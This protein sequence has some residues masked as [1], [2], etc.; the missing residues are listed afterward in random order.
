MKFVRLVNLLELLSKKSHLLLGPRGTGKSYLIREQL[1]EQALVINLLEQ[2]LFLRLTAAPWE[3]RSMVRAA[4]TGM[5]IVI[6]EIQKI[7]A[8]MDE[9][10]SL[11]ESEGRI[12]LLTG[13]SARR[14]RRG[15]ANLLAGRAW[16]AE[17]LPLTSQE[18]PNLDL[19]RYLRFGGLPFVYASPNPEEELHAYVK[20]YLQEEI[21]AEG[22]TRNLPAFTRFLTTAAM[23][24]GTVVNYT[25]VGA[26]AEV[27]PSTVRQY[28]QVLEDTLLGFRVAP[29]RD[30][31]K[32][33]AV[34]TE[35]FYLFDIGVTHAIAGTKFIERNSDLYG[36]SFEHFIA[37]EL[38]AYISY[39]R[40][41]EPLLFWRSTHGSEV[42]FIVDN[43][44]AIEVKAT[45]R[46][47]RSDLKGLLAFQ[48][49]GL[50]NKCILVSQ[51]PVERLD[52][53]IHIIPWEIFLH[54][55]WRE[56]L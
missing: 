43:R 50:G 7:P 25:K 26:D 32:R 24:S 47:Q 22:I 39:R 17:M 29:K 21:Q 31:K 6:D 40:T 34:A 11:I 42:D 37:Q 14:L 56:Q 44:F 30:T 3:I 12:F 1:A 4:P 35:K 53:N 28:L 51:D 19:Q 27:S 55:L 38:R 52:Q 15:G 23:L 20:T 5:T 54:R 13:S 49:E 18:I 45:Q 10:H 36:R 8:L 33:K 48:E 46:V 2:N 16:L 41:H 9:V